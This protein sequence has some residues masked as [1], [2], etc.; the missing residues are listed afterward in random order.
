VRRPAFL[1]GLV[2]VGLVLILT[3]L[4]S[5]KGVATNDDFYRGKTLTIVVG[6][7]SGGAY[8]AYGRL[9]ARHL[10]D[11]IP[12]SPSVVVENMPGVGGLSALRYLEVNAST[13]GTYIA[14]FNAGLITQSI[15]SP[16]TVNMKFSDLY[17]LG[18]VTHE[19]RVCYAWHTTGIKSW[20]DLQASDRFILGGVGVGTAEYLDGRI[21]SNVFG[22]RIKQ[23]A[24]YRGSADER[25][26]I[27]RGE[28]D[29][30]CSEWN[31]QPP[32]W[33]RE[34]KIV[35]FVK[36]LR[37]APVGFPQDVPYIVDLA[38]SADD[39][40][41]LESFATPSE[42][43]NPFAASRKAPPERLEILRKAFSETIADRNF[44]EEA[45]THA[46]P[47]EPTNGLDAQ[48]LVE[49]IYESATPALV[50]HARNAMK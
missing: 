42:L 10:G 34:G 37:E 43:G 30:A 4:E 20:K 24:G 36:W 45:T 6:S 13:D 40:A 28:L 33:I 39:R 49:A 7:A 1:N 17:W 16:E 21:L 15:V 29:G 19:F 3:T 32:D 11:H 31:A 48:N 35:P 9:L 18:S 12:G 5:R 44:L 26:A 47:V 27:E 25:L 50:E 23:I 2:L 46:M 38:T 14:T 22:I 41:T 8:D